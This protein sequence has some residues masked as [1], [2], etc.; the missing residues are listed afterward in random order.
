MNFIKSASLSSIPIMMEINRSVDQIMD[1]EDQ[2]LAFVQIQTASKKKFMYQG[3][4]AEDFCK[5]WTNYLMALK[6][7][8]E[9]FCRAT[10]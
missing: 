4:F 9:S 3:S 7:N 8:L 10:E 2:V 6:S 1:D 5:V